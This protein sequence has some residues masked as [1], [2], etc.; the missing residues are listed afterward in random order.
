[1]EKL[2]FVFHSAEAATANLSPQAERFAREVMPLARAVTL[3][4][5]RFPFILVHS[6]RI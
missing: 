5:E 4:L 6:H 3:H 1:M 2:C